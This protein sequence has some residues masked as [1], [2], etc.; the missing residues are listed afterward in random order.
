MAGE[1]ALCPFRYALT[2]LCGMSVSIFLFTV[3]QKE[4]I[5]SYPSY[6]GILWQTSVR[7]LD[8]DKGELNPSIREF[9]NQVDQLPLC[10][11]SQRQ[12]RQK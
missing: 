11:P 1:V 9:L 4:R 2:T 8:F 5:R 7:I 3:T 6:Q 12:V 10:V